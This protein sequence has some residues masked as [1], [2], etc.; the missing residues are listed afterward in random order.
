[1]P[2][3]LIQHRGQVVADIFTRICNKIWQT[4]EWPTP[5]RQPLIITLPKKAISKKIRHLHKIM[6]YTMERI[7]HYH[8]P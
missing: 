6:A 8:S 5:W 3:E 7:T 4:G 1:M 2:A